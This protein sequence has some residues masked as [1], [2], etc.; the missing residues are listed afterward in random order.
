M[1]VSAVM[2]WIGLAAATLFGQEPTHRGFDFDGARRLSLDWRASGRISVSR[3][4]L[5]KPEA[6]AAGK[7]LLVKAQRKSLVETKGHPWSGIADMERLRLSIRAMDASPAQPRETRGP[8]LHRASRR[9][10]LAKD[11]TRESGVGA[12]GSPA[13][14]VPVES[15]SGASLGRGARLPPLFP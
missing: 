11:R 7:G 3:E 13:L 6:G 5:E 9:V 12:A 8:V 14:A 1:R 2:V 4:V 15:R 10:V